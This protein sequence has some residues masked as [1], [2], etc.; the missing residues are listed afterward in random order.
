[1]NLNNGWFKKLIS[2]VLTTGAL[3]NNLLKKRPILQI[4]FAV[5]WNQPDV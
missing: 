1:M 4:P 2:T 5:T 3:G